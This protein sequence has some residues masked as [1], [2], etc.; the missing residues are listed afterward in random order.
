MFRETRNQNLSKIFAI[1]QKTFLKKFY[2]LK[3]INNLNNLLMDLKNIKNIIM[4][5]IKST[6]FYDF[7]IQNNFVK[8]LCFAKF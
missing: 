4:L 8:I 5:F 1:S 6:R 2:I 3:V 7:E